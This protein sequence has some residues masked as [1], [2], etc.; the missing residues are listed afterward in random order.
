MRHCFL[1]KVKIPEILLLCGIKVK[2]FFDY[3]NDDDD[4]K[5]IIND[6]VVDDCH[7]IED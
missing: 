3:E 4:E 5:L 1:L 6:R 2:Y 7:I